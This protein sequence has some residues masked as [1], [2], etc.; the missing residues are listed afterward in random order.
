LLPHH[1]LADAA[2]TSLM[3]IKAVQ[4]QISTVPMEKTA[5]LMQIKAVH[6][7]ISTV[8]MQKACFDAN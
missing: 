5:V 2:K 4:I 7:Q 1:I 8:P 3:Q 6:M